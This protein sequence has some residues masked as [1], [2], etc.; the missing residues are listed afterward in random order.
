MWPPAFYAFSVRG[1]P[2]LAAALSIAGG[3]RAQDVRAAAAAICAVSEAFR[4]ARHMPQGRRGAATEALRAA[5][6]AV[7]ER[8]WAR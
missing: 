8:A 3:G 1:D 6:R 2:C 4:L 5:V 7:R